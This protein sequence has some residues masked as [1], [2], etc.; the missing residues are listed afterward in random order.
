MNALPQEPQTPFETELRLAQVAVLGYLVRLTGHLADARDLLQET[1]LTAWDKRESFV[2]GTSLVAWM[3]A[4]ALNHYRNATRREL[5]R[6]TVSILDDDLVAMVETRHLEREREETRK[7]RFLQLCLGKLPERQRAVI[8][9][10]YYD[11]ASLEEIGSA[12]SRKAN[13]MAQLLHRARLNLIECVR[14]ESHRDLDHESFP[15][16]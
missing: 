5:A 9:S 10:Y 14:R 2:P 6:R 13:A 3:R 15:P 16:L 11:G 4:I 1:N 7:R 8:E 12:H